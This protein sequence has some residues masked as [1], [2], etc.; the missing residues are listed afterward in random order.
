MNNSNL[1]I[2]PHTNNN[3]VD[4]NAPQCIDYT[5]YVFN[6]I[7]KIGWSFISIVFY[8][9]PMLLCT[10]IIIIF[11]LIGLFFLGITYGYGLVIC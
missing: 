4:S 10:L 7:M 5:Y 2:D 3:T 9:I 11:M 8:I 1:N 6:F